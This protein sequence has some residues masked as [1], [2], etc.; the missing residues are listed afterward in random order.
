MPARIAGA[1][2]PRCHPSTHELTRS[3]ASAETERSACYAKRDSQPA[4]GIKNNIRPAG[5]CPNIYT[6]NWN[7][8]LGARCNAGAEGHPQ[9]E[10]MLCNRSATTGMNEYVTTSRVTSAEIPWDAPVYVP[11][12]TPATPFCHARDDRCLQRLDC[13]L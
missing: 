3:L 8:A 9:D 7:R 5:S 1:L 11:A 2:A 13:L 6:R 10:Q 4:T 12:R